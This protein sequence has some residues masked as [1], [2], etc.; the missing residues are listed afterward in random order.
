[1]SKLLRIEGYNPDWKTEFLKL[2]KHLDSILGSAHITIIHIGSTSVPQ[3]DA[4]PIIDIDIVFKKN[5]E[6]IKDILIHNN[7]LYRGDLGIKDRYSFSYLKD[8]FYE[9]HLYVILE[10]SDALRN[11]IKLKEALLKSDRYRKEY[12]ALKRNLIQNNNTDRNLYTNSK[13]RL[14][15]KIIMEDNL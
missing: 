10:G 1:M 9:H 8:D 15:N 11:H 5:F 2:K 14:I 3:M 13:T 7:Y 4:K 12:S 6:E